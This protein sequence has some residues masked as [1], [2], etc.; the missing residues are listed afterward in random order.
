MSA[1]TLRPQLWTASQT[2]ANPLKLI[3]IVAYALLGSLVLMTLIQVIKSGLLNWIPEG[4]R[5][6]ALF[7]ITPRWFGIAFN[8]WTLSSM[9]I[10]IG[11]P[12]LVLLIWGRAPIVRQIFIPYIALVL[13][14]GVSEAFF[15]QSLRLINPFV[16]LTYTSFRVY[17]LWYGQQLFATAQQPRGISHRIVRGTLV[18]GLGFW[19]LN[20][21][22]L[23]AIIS[24]QLARAYGLLQF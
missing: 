20:L 11:L 4:D 9:F 13:I 7:R 17:Q 14:H 19:S 12:L 1:S 5:G 10:S 6:L 24:A 16:G 18:L 23:A 15:A 3:N 21:L 2:R 22:L 8:Y